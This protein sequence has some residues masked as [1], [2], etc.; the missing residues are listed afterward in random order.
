MKLA[1]ALWAGLNNII[2]GLRIADNEFDTPGPG[3]FCD[4]RIN[5]ILVL[6]LDL[7]FLV[8]DLLFLES[9]GWINDVLVVR[10]IVHRRRRV[11]IP[12]L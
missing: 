1:F 5:L 9:D 6:V 8:L 2:V 7:L 4:R 11:P 12:N 3:S 10:V